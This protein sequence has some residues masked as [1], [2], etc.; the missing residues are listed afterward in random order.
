MKGPGILGNFAIART[1]HYMV[2]G[3][4]TGLAISAPATFAVLV[5]ATGSPLVSAYAM[6][7]ILLVVASLFAFV[8]TNLGWG[9]GHAEAI[10][11]T[12][13]LGFAVDYCVHIAHA[14]LH[15]RRP[16]RGGKAEEALA[17]MGNTVVAGAVTTIGSGTAMA[18]CQANIY[19]KMG[20]LIIGTIAFSVVYTLFFF[21]PL[22]AVA[23]PTRPPI[24]FG[25]AA[26]CQRCC[27]PLL[28]LGCWQPAPDHPHGLASW[29]SPW[30]SSRSSRT[31][32]QQE[33]ASLAESPGSPRNVGGAI[34]PTASPRS[35]FSTGRSAP[36]HV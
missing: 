1:T 33:G 16:T 20:V 19:H 2:S 4:V 11:G 3:L 23:G 32:K 36:A 27:A 14:Y 7:T 22:C 15:S 6:V 31:S 9:L 13:V 25:F 21:A 8:S 34:S 10:A 26:L 24:K 29:S 17:T 28:A 18:M 35:S 30:S 5:L 12:M